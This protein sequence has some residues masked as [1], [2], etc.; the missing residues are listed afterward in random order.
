MLH[1]KPINVQKKTLCTFLHVLANWI[2]PHQFEATTEA[3]LVERIQC[4]NSLKESQLEDKIVELYK[5][6]A[7]A[8]KLA[9]HFTY[10]QDGCVSYSPVGTW[11]ALSELIRHTS[12]THAQ[13]QMNEDMQ[14]HLFDIRADASRIVEACDSVHESLMAAYREAHPASADHETVDKLELTD[15]V[16]PT[17]VAS[18]KNSL[19]HIYGKTV[20]ILDLLTE[21]SCG[22]D[23]SWRMPLENIIDDNVANCYRSKLGPG[24]ASAIANNATA[25]TNGNAT[26]NTNDSATADASL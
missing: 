2:E 19:I 4:F 7:S 18:L 6:A 8:L 15:A 13:A 14:Y 12:M 16:Q 5:I 22:Q 3:Q 20:H 24:Y 17:T 23:W 1:D 11:S 26:A 9:E 10:T 25:N 21:H